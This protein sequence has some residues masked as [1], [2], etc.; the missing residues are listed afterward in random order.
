VKK[1]K[2]QKALFEP[3]HLLYNFVS[4]SEFGRL[5]GAKRRKP[6]FSLQFLGFAYA[7]P[8]GFRGR[9]SAHYN[10]IP[11]GKRPSSG[12]FSLQSLAQRQLKTRP[13]N[14]R[15][16]ELPSAIPQL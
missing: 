13:G 1:K 4:I 8:V 11:I 15:G 5:S 2:R 6:G 12:A 3:V 9:V 16:A 7:N 14:C 10:P